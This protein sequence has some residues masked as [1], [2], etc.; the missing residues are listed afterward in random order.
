M[1]DPAST[2]G[3][4]W[5]CGAN[6]R[7]SSTGSAANARPGGGFFGGAG[8]ASVCPYSSIFEFN[9][10]D[11]HKS[12]GRD[13]MQSG[14]TSGYNLGVR[15]GTDQVR[16]F[17]SGDWADDTGIVDYN[18]LNRLSLR[19]NVDVLFSEDLTVSFN[20]G[21]TDGFTSYGQQ[22]QI[23]AGFWTELLFA[24]GDQLV[25][26][27][28]NQT[29]AQVAGGLPV[30]L[31]TGPVAAYSTA[32]AG[33]A[34]GFY[35]RDIKWYELVESTRDY[36]RLTASLTSQ[37][38][39]G[40]WL[41]QRLVFGVDRNWA[42]ERYYS[43]VCPQGPNAVHP[44]RNHCDGRVRESDD[45]DERISFD[46]NASATYQMNDMLTFTTSAGAQYNTNDV[47]TFAA[48]GDGLPSSLFNSLGNV[49][50][51]T[52]LPT[53]R[54]T[55]A[56]SLGFFFQE[57]VGIND[58]L[59]LTGAVR[60]DDNS[61]FGV[62]A[63]LLYYPKVSASWVIS[64]E[65]FFNLPVLDE[66]RLRGAFGKSGRAPNAFAR[67]FQYSEATG[68]TGLPAIQLSS[69][70]NPA[71]GP[72]VSSELEMGVDFALLD[73]RVSGEF[74]YFHQW[75][76]DALV[77]ESL[78]PSEAFTGSIQTNV[79]GLNNWGWET[80]LDMQLVRLQPVQFDL[81]LSASH[82]DNII[83]TLTDE[84][85]SDNF[86]EG[87]YYPN[88]TFTRL[89]SV[90]LLPAGTC[91]TGLPSGGPT[92]PV[93]AFS[94][95]RNFF[96]GTDE[97]YMP[98]CDLGAPGKEKGATSP[99]GIGLFP[100]GRSIQCDSAVNFYDQELM[101][102]RAYPNYTLQVAPT[103][104]F[105]NNTL[106][107]H[108]LAEGQYGRWIF[109]VDAQNRSGQG[110]VG[111]NRQNTVVGLTLNDP[112]MWAAHYL[113]NIDDERWQG[114]FNA[115]FW[116][117][118]ELGVRYQLPRSLV[119]RARVDRASISVSGRHLWE[120]W[121]RQHK[122]WSGAPIS[123]AENTNNYSGEP[124]YTVEQLPGLSSWTVTL[125]VSF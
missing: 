21:Y 60:A 43:P 55:E 27:P 90:Q 69:A 107:V 20:M 64:E 73:Q 112:E 78:S 1:M 34:D 92:C 77:S 57:T 86:V 98:W 75:V 113:R 121:R 52:N 14:Y 85:E 68:P 119:E 124:N 40:D 58:R 32:P 71:V 96:D 66:V 67:T 22:S 95:P 25:D 17:V 12:Q 51:L 122:D 88:V 45:V 84:Q 47:R 118:R 87:Y 26:E 48:D 81:R 99:A 72:E 30:G 82:T 114:R 46:Y 41:T 125:R 13:L 110:I 50:A 123:E 63:D 120:I 111:A 83:V 59:F 36:A 38:T 31:Q 105:L 117:L 9:V 54:E 2:L 65:P 91:V 3:D 37:H 18:Y 39:V 7:I 28:L 10:Y 16:Y 106:E 15:G 79:G 6:Q 35:E 29:T 101:A 80:A 4:Q 5:G 61:G 76:R 115:A 44:F 24:Q 116:K 62:D 8:V 100:G 33:D 23:D 56:R 93:G 53:Y 42:R 11:Y 70:G 103:L 49:A 102:G 19:T 74:T 104:R 108:A 89:D 94:D 109:D 97:W